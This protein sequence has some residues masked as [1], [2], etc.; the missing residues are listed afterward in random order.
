MG[1]EM[2]SASLGDVLDVLI[3][4][5]GRT[6]KKL[7][8]DFSNSG[9]R[10]LSAKNIKDGRIDLSATIRYVGREMHDR[11]MRVKLRTGDVLLTS[12]APLGEVAFLNDDA[13]FCLGQRLFALRPNSNILDSQI[14][15]AHV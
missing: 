7:G 13:D 8:G 14:G 3:D 6:P 9:V 1:S 15:R 5:R 11:W 10:V 4:H 2:T 12:E